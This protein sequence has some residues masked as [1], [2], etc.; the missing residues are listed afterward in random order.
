MLPLQHSGFWEVLVFSFNKSSCTSQYY[1]PGSEASG[2]WPEFE[3]VLRKWLIASYNNSSGRKIEG[4]RI[5][6]APSTCAE[7][8]KCLILSTSRSKPDVTL[9]LKYIT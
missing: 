3:K 9:L 4:D 8:S 6:S 5:I 2:E 7:Q 1:E